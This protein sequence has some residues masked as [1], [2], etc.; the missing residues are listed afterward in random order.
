MKNRLILPTL[1][2]LLAFPLQAG[3]VYE[4]EVKDHGQST[5]KTESIEAA[6]EGRHLKMGIA[7]Q[8]KGAQGEMIFRG[9][10]REVVVVDHE[11]RT[12]HKIDQEAIGRCAESFA[13]RPGEL[14]PAQSLEPLRA[15]YF[16]SGSNRPRTRRGASRLRRFL[17]PGGNLAS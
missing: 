16:H 12:Y 9:D 1:T 13:E 14:D 2:L 3:V 4:I 7:S 8:G 10:R 6:V 11:N 17:A 15:R 5:P